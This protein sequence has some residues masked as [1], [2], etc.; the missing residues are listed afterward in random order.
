[1]ENEKIIPIKTHEKSYVTEP[2]DEEYAELAKRLKYSVYKYIGLAKDESIVERYFIV[3]ATKKDFVIYF[4]ELEEYIQS[5]SRKSVRPIQSNNR[6]KTIYITKMLNYILIDNYDKY[7]IKSVSYLTP[8]SVIDFLAHYASTESEKTKERP[9]KDSIVFV[10]NS[11]SS[12]LE[13]IKKK[14]YLPNFEN[15]DLFK[16]KKLYIQG[17]ERS[18]RVSALDTTFYQ[19]K[20]K[21]RLYDMPTPILFRL[22]EL[23]R[24]HDPMILLPMAMQAF[25]GLRAGEVCNIRQMYSKHGAG[26]KLQIESGHITKATI[27]IRYVYQMRSDGVRVGRIKKPRQQSIYPAFLSLFEQ[28][29]NNHMELLKKYNY[30]K[31]YAPMFLSKQNSNGTYKAMRYAAYQRRFSSIVDILIGELIR[32]STASERAYAELLL[33]HDVGTHILRHW[34]SVQLVLH[35][36][37]Q[38]GIMNWRGD[39]NPLSAIIYLQNKG[40]LIKKY[41]KVG[42]TLGKYTISQWEDIHD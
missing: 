39:K 31:E 25:G 16:D 24:I 35:G 18:V 13:A 34:F 28:I 38:V 11:I 12:F 36:E 23:T 19:T 27:D 8:E 15:F 32:S 22:F 26:I 41:K 33:S 14:S 2:Y 37:N 9:S 42:D 3:I 4:T 30:E 20:Q 5:Y 29:Y 6:Q 40:E 7:K 1:M 10:Q 21:P 17:I